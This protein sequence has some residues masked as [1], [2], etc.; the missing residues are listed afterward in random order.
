MTEASVLCEKLLDTIGPNPL[1]SFLFAAIDL[2]NGELVSAIEHLK[3]AIRL[4]PAVTEY[5]LTLANTQRSLGIYEDAIEH[6][7]N[8]CWPRLRLQHGDEQRGCKNYD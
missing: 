3:T 5:H 4:D 6:Y 7:E 2:K 1:I 8:A